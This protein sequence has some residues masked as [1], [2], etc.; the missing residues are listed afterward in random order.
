MLWCPA[1]WELHF[2]KWASPSGLQYAVMDLVW[3][4][5]FDALHR[6]KIEIQFHFDLK[7]YRVHSDSSE[8]DVRIPLN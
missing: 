4:S 8:M 7:K 3:S 1:Q 2:E 6:L 5:M